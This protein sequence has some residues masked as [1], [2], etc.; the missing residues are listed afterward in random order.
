[1]ITDVM[2]PIHGLLF[3]FGG[4]MIR[5]VNIGEKCYGRCIKK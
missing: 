4:T 5:M 2:P 3:D 1:M